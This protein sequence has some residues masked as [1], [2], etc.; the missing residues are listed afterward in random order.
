MDSMRARDLF[1]PAVLTAAVLFI[2]PSSVLCADAPATR[3]LLNASE[4]HD[5]VK[6]APGADPA[7]QQSFLSFLD[8]QDLVMFH[9]KF[10]YYSSGRVSFGTD[11]QTYPIAL[12]PYFGQMIAEQIFRMWQGMRRAGSL[13]PGDRFTIAEFGAGNGLL[14]ESI[15]EYLENKAREQ[16]ADPRWRDFRSQVLYVCYD[17]SA[18]LSRAQRER[19]ARFGS[20]FE[21]REA[22]ATDPTAAVPPGSLKGVILSN[23]LPDAF[24]VHKVI[25]STD[26]SAEVAFV[27]PSLP[28]ENWA[29]LEKI[30]PADVTEKVVQGDRNVRKA[31]LTARQDQT[32]LSRAAFAALLEA[33]ISSKEYEP[34]VQSLQFHELYL[35]ASMVPELAGHLRRHASSYARALA[36]L[37][38]GVVTYIN[39][40]AEQFIRGA[41]S[42]LKAGYV[43][44]VDYGSNWEGILGQDVSH[45]RTYGPAHR[46]A[47]PGFGWDYDGQA[48]SEW[49]TSDPYRGPTLNDM[50][51]DVNFS[52]LAAEGDL[53]VLRTVYYGPQAALRSG[54][55]ISF[56]AFDDWAS[57]FETD[58]HYRLMVQQKQGTDPSYSYPRD[59][60][61]PLTSGQSGWSELQRRRAAE[62]EKRLGAAGPAQPSGADPGVDAGAART[63][64]ERDGRPQRL[65]PVPVLR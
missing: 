56:P 36:K 63:N 11:Y 34:L 1:A 51:T 7:V 40:G 39:L 19:N 33:L 17:R 22:D 6:R 64:R 50:T 38:Q 21:A 42:I 14:A 61:D 55:P 28:R 16:E 44:T 9:P 5:E 30:V 58:G 26:G 18:A 52:L 15:L 31:L 37:D 12:A 29:K 3:L 60:Q 57:T 54:T 32:Y 8:Y 65:D 4:I 59:H 20:R 25:L 35:P 46:D 47:N 62:I 45:F 53:T 27:A 48:A 23:E 41:G 49:V 2:L 13:E 43:V 24:S 10:G